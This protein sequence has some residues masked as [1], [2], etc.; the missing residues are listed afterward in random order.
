LDGRRATFP[1]MPC[2]RRFWRVG[3]LTMRQLLTSGL[4]WFSAIG[5]GLLAGAYFA[6]STFV[7][8]SLARWGQPGAV[9]MLAG[10]VLYVLGMFIVTMVF[11]VRSTTRSRRSIRQ[12]P[13]GHRFGR[14]I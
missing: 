5:C 6:F 8:T 13:K 4:L 2:D 14:A 3:G 1:T 10:G 12:A 11:N 7:M 9:A